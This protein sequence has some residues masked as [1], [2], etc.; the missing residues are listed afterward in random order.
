MD[1]APFT[2]L[3]AWAGLLVLLRLQKPAFTLTEKGNQQ[4]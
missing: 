2:V 1:E 4:G 3:V